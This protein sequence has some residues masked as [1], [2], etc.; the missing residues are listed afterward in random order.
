MDNLIS[1]LRAEMNLPRSAPGHPATALPGADRQDSDEGM[2]AEEEE[3]ET[4]GQGDDD[5]GNGNGSGAENRPNKRKADELTLSDT[6]DAEL[7]ALRPK[8]GPG[9]KLSRLQ[10]VLNSPYSYLQAHEDVRFLS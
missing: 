3:E 7:M 10:A 2:I 9:L 4:G 8:K 5:E 6:E 1:R